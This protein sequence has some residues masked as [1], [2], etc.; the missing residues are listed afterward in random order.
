MRALGGELGSKPPPIPE[1]FKSAVSGIPGAVLQIIEIVETVKGNVDDARDLALYIGQVTEAA[2]RPLQ[3][4]PPNFSHRPLEEG[5]EDFHQTL[6]VV[7]EQIR[8][9]L[10]R[11]RV[12]RVLHYRSNA[13]KIASMKQRVRDVISYIQLETT[14]TTTYG[15]VQIAQKQTAAGSCWMMS[16]RFHAF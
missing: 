9:L 15:V 13:A 14:F 7:Q 11:G 1:P 5:L 2:V 3:G 10:S 6:E 4:M 12:T 8:T 16:K